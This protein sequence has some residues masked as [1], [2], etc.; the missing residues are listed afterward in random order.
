MNGCN[1]RHIHRLIFDWHWTV[2]FPKRSRLCKQV[3]RG[4]IHVY[5]IC[6][7]QAKAIQMNRKTQKPLHMSQLYLAV[8]YQALQFPL[9]YERSQSYAQP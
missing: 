8:H 1:G 5:N 9:H 7:M 4:V 3:R 2:A 6:L